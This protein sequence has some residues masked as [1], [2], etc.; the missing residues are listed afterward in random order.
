MESNSVIYLGLTLEC[1]DLPTNTS[2]QRL[3]YAPSPG[4]QER[5]QKC[6]DTQ[7]DCG[8]AEFALQNDS[9]MYPQGSVQL[10]V[11]LLLT[12]LS[13]LVSLNFPRLQCAASYRHITFTGTRSTA[14]RAGI[15]WQRLRKLTAMMEVLRLQPVLWNIYI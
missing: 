12:Y 1:I 7:G 13:L 3:S 15:R 5:L 10:Y 2:Y 14:V 4:V 9:H 6:S 8:D 11:T